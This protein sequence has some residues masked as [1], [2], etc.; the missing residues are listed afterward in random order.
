VEMRGGL[1]KEAPGN[2]AQ[3]VRRSPTSPTFM[4]VE[5]TITGDLTLQWKALSLLKEPPP[6]DGDS[7]LF[8]VR[9][10]P[11][12]F[13]QFGVSPDR[14]YI[15]LLFK[16]NI[17]YHHAM[18][19]LLKRRFESNLEQ[20]QYPYR[21]FVPRFKEEVSF[22]LQIRL[23]P[24]NILVMTAKL[25]KVPVQL[26]A[27][28]LIRIQDLQDLP[29]ISDIIRRT[30]GMVE[31]LDHHSGLSQNG[32]RAKPLIHIRTPLS[33][34]QFEVEVAEHTTEYV[35]IVI[36]NLQYRRMNAA[37]TQGVI[38]KS[39][40]LG[41]KS[42]DELLLVD[43][44]GILDISANSGEAS[45]QH[46]QRRLSRFHDL[47]ELAV[48]FSSFLDNFRSLRARQE[49]LADF[50]ISRISPWI[51]NSDAVLA[52]SVTNRSAWRLLL[53]EFGLQAQLTAATEGLAA[54][55]DEKRPY[56]DQVDRGWWETTEL[57]SILSKRLAALKGLQLGFI[58]DRE[59]REL[60][61]VDYEEA[62][63]SLAARNYKSVILLCG[64]IIEA[65]L[66]DAL[67][68]A[69]KPGLT[70]A[71]L[72]NYGLA[73]LIREAEQQEIINDKVLIMHL[74]PIR[75]YRNMIHP[76]VQVR[77]SIEPDRS[78]AQIAM[79]TANLLIKELKR[80]AGK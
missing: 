16:P 49:D 28:S 43:K 63:R 40:P 60:V 6:I 79:E 56:F 24:P 52:E 65:L 54:A 77:K 80:S 25:S 75:H 30:I 58:D 39:S 44:Q 67:A 73:D 50:L 26:S 35:G 7:V 21:I 18:R 10:N 46:L 4:H 69:N 51:V 14:N 66:A 64:S 9:G 12:A 48:V 71:K 11:G 34:S 74:E 76:G 62:R 45:D 72:L 37:V 70:R 47:M 1:W 36:R 78:R 33:S 20:L 15:P 3:R 41:V 8:K 38:E 19:T 23:Y 13:T 55:F 32:F 27:E 2:R 42:S 31:T 53:N 17:A 61:I 57:T 29:P 22:A 59:L 68:Q 5:S